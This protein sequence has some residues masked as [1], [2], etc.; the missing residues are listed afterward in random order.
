[1]VRRTV[2]VLAVDDPRLVGMQLE[3]TAPQ[4]RGESVQHQPG[5]HLAATVDDAESRAGESHPH[6]LAELCMNLSTHTA[7]IIQPLAARASSEQ[8]TE[9]GFALRAPTSAEL[10]EDAHA[11]SCT[12]APPTGPRPGPRGA[13][14]DRAQTCRNW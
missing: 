5:L 11:A 3:P 2:H 1:M 13:K 9:A 7:P 10:A 6:A 8:T 4:P 12:S 14:W